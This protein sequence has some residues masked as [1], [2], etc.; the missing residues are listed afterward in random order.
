MKRLH[1]LIALCALPYLTLLC[2]QH[3]Q[4]RGDSAELPDGIKNENE[5]DIDCGGMLDLCRWEGVRVRCKLSVR[6]L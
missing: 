4:H 5:S 6:R 3:R 2:G 1:A